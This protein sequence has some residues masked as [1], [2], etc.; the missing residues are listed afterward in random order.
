MKLVNA[1]MGSGWKEEDVDMCGAKIYNLES[2]S[3]VRDGIT[4]EDDTLAHRI[5]EECLNGARS[6]GANT[7]KENFQKMLW[8]YY[9]LRGWD[10][11]GVPIELV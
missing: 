3:A 4:G 9:Q 6:E 11:N 10:E 5:M 2:S 7:G 8:E 1:T